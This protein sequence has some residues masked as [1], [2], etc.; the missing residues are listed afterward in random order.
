MLYVSLGDGTVRSLDLTT[1]QGRAEWSAIVADHSLP[2]RGL[3]L[4]AAGRRADLPLPKRFNRVDL[5]ADVIC[6]ASGLPVAERVSACADDVVLCLTLHLGGRG[7][8]VRVDLDR[9]GRSR[10]RPTSR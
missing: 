10:F 3:A 2:V 1:E 8:R 6:D 5:T 7:A 9:R 4:A